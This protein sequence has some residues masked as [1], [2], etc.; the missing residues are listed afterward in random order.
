LRCTSGPSGGDPIGVLLRT[1]SPWSRSRSK[2]FWSV[3]LAIAPLLGAS[4]AFAV[5]GAAEGAR[6]AEAT[7]PV[8]A[9]APARRPDPRPRAPD[10][11]AAPAADAGTD[12]EARAASR[13]RDPRFFVVPRL[14]LL[15]RG[16]AQF[17][18]A[19]SSSGS[20]GCAPEPA[21]S[22]RDD[23]TLRLELAA[24]Y[25]V[26]GPLR[27]GASAGAVPRVA[28]DDGESRRRFGTELAGG[29]V[30]EVSVP[31]SPRVSAIGRISGG[32]VLL[33]AGKDLDD[34]AAKAQ[35]DCDAV[36]QQGVACSVE[37]G[38]YLGLTFG[39]SAGASWQ[40]GAGGGPRLRSELAYE[41]YRI[42]TVHQEAST[43]GG[44]MT[45]DVELHGSRLWLLAGL[46]L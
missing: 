45:G 35:R 14:G 9:R 19:C 29:A 39:A 1:R 6:P 42:D 2:F 38:P 34:E 26:L 27:I 10:P 30:L 37:D 12:A 44:E 28:Y 17:N 31:V 41:R 25:R 24:L 7:P 16:E 4:T 15:L 40:L 33:I 11:G 46:E 13:R 18:E 32:P 20:L 3:A 36:T 23:S 22:Y 21:E 8:E 43:A 5:D